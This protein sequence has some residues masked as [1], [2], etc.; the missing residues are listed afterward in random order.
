MVG[1][2]VAVI[3]GII[4]LTVTAATAGLALHKDIKTADLIRDWHGHS[5]ELWTLQTRTY[6][7]TVK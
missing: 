3:L 6:S 2:I 1:L 5:T 7:E 4:A